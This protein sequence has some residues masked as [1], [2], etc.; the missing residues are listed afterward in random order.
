MIWKKSL[1]LLLVEGRRM[2][3]QIRNDNGTFQLPG[4][5]FLHKSEMLTLGAIY[6]SG[7]A[8]LQVSFQVLR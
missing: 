1:C 8:K 5:T 6:P 2:G 7:V 4:Y 3:V